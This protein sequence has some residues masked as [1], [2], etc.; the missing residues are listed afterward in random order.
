MTSGRLP[1]RVCKR[2]QVGLEL[3]F[4]FEEDVEADEIEERELKVFGRGV[5]DVRDEGVGGSSSVATA[6]EGFFQGL[7]DSPAPVP[8]HDRSSD[9]VADRIGEHGRVAGAFTNTAAHTIGDG[10]HAVRCALGQ[11]GDVL[12]PGDADEDEEALLLC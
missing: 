9:I 3:L 11:K 10:S 4:R 1:A 12:F 2:R 6:V 7:L 5:V 8:A